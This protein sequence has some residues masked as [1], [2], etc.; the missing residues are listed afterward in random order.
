M[1][2]LGQYLKQLGVEDPDRNADSALPNLGLRHHALPRVA[3]LAFGQE[4]GKE[5]GTSIGP[6]H[7]SRSAVRRCESTDCGNTNLPGIREGDSCN[8]ILDGNVSSEQHSPHSDRRPAP[9][10]ASIGRDFLH[11][12]IY[13]GLPGRPGYQQSFPYHGHHQPLCL[14]RRAVCKFSSRIPRKKTLPHRR[15][16]VSRMLHADFLIRQFWIGHPCKGHSKC[17]YR[18][19]VHLV[20]HLREHYITCYLGRLCGDALSA[21]EDVWSSA[22]TI[23]QLHLRIL[24]VILDSLYDKSVARKHGYQRGLLLFWANRHTHHSYGCFRPRNGPAEAGAD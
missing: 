8:H 16:V 21:T 2:R 22:G 5:G 15:L 12:T 10:H 17:T 13:C 1:R 7:G 3:T 4:Q 11:H 14:C 9:P 18:L 20:F 19:L 23:H 6:I 24:R